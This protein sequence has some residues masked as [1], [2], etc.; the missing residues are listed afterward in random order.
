MAILFQQAISELH[1]APVSQWGYTRSHWYE[2]YF[3]SSQE[4]FCTWSCFESEDYWNSEMAYF[5]LFYLLC[6]MPAGTSP[7]DNSHQQSC[8][9]DGHFIQFRAYTIL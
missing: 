9:N 4:K 1:K 5:H 6:Y 2:T 7:E 3:N 8:P